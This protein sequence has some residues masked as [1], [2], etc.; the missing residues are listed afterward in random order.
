MQPLG[1]VRIQDFVDG[2]LRVIRRGSGVRRRLRLRVVGTT[3]A[4]LLAGALLP[5]FFT[6]GTLL[7]Q[8]QTQDYL[9]RLRDDP[10]IDHLR[11]QPAVQARRMNLQEDEAT[12]YRSQLLARQGNLRR[13][14]AALPLAEV[15][16]QM[17]TVYNG[18]AVRLRPQDVAAVESLPEVA[19]VIP[20]I[21]YH[22]VLDA[23]AALV[24]L[25][26]AWS[27][28][29]IGGEDNAGAGVRIAVIDTGIDINHPMLQDPSLVP[30]AGFPR[31]TAATLSC[32]ASDQLFTNS[33]VIVA[34]NYVRLLQNPDLNCDAMDRD[35]HGT[36]VSGIAAGHRRQAPLASIAGAAPKAFL[37]SYKVF[38]TPG[39]ND[40]TPDS[41]LI[42]AIDDAVKDGMD[43]INI[44]LGADIPLPPSL[45]ELAQAVAAAVNA[46]VTVVAA[47]GNGGPAT[48][49][50]TSPGTSPAAITVGST[51]NARLLANPLVIS[52][53][54]AVPPEIQ[55]IATL[56]S[57][58][59][60]ITFDIGPAP[61]T[62]TITLDGASTACD[63]LPAASLT[64]RIALIRRGGCSFETK[65]LYATFAGAIAVVI[66][67]HH[68][69][70]PP[71]PM[72]VGLAVQIPSVM[73]GNTEGT[74]L[75]SYL[76]AVGPATTATLA[77]RQQA[78][79]TTANHVSS[80]SAAGP[81]TDFGIKPDLVAP[82]ENIYSAAQQNFPAGLQ[83]DATGFTSSSGT[84]FSSPLVAGAAALVKQTHPEFSP[85]QIKSALVQTAVPGVTPFADGVT[86][87]LALGNGLMDADAALAT[88]AT[89]SPASISFGT[90]AP[91]SN[92][93]QTTGLSITNV[94]SA[95]DTFT[96]TAPASSIGA[97]AT[98]TA[99]PASFT[100]APGATTNISIRATSTQPIIGTVEGH[101]ALVSQNTGQTLT[102]PY[103]GNFLLPRIN[104]NGIV[105]AASL[106]SGPAPV[107]AG[108]LVSIFGI[109][110]SS[111]TTVAAGA[112]PLPTS[113]AGIR[114]LMR[115]LL[116]PPLLYEEAPLLFV[117]PTQIIA[118]VPQ[119]LAGLTSTTVRVVHNGNSSPAPPLTLAPTGPGIFAVNQTGSG[120]AAVLHA[121]S[122][123]PVSSRDPAKRN[124]LLELYVNGLGAT[125][126]AVETGEPAPLNPLAQ[127]IFLPTVTL[128]D[129]PAPVRFAG[130]APS[131]VGLYQVNIEVPSNAPSGEVPL[132][133]TSN[134]VISNIVT[135]SVAP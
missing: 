115:N 49:T 55:I 41:A 37:G 88:P 110:M 116:N 117:S 27:D 126:L 102:I 15:R 76:A 87:V 53:P 35:G 133:L 34:R 135:I 130:L 10:V 97:P 120:A 85:A 39:V 121:S 82:G 14:I 123:R 99:T 125:T 36:F 93:N 30:P 81:S 31:F 56:I 44:S 38:G 106:V 128:G 113:L 61:L 98:L 62:D 71:T 1:W 22:K 70:Q 86:G 129:M 69:Q 51:T 52:G 75:A 20:A 11:R 40:K 59:P 103:W 60:A 45:D 33:K 29:R 100:V 24:Q 5:W 122:R 107:A 28:A 94:T 74:A 114:V 13:Q 68:F 54:I 48:G 42:K 91:G 16:A 95:T 19:A 127:V 25:P 63:P 46:G 134:G 65:I 4:L 7:A 112:T 118:Q 79:P 6:G 66:Y 78:I 84:S 80:F 104:T 58:G 18:L 43:I 83:Y 50:I 8:E 105:N 132:I 109:Q 92:L 77:A 12:R 90:N 21:L 17:D 111:G 89:V 32:P 3:T 26:K 124:E 101:L 9:V 2:A 96:I 67:N 64:G 72:G 57:N 23:A 47:A 108:S 119:E 131:F 73:I